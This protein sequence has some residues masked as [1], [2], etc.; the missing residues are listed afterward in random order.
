MPAPKDQTTN[1]QVMSRPMS[2]APPMEE[3]YTALSAPPPTHPPWAAVPTVGE[4]LLH[5][6]VTLTDLAAC[7]VSVRAEFQVVKRAFLALALREHPDRWG[8]PTGSTDP[9]N[10]SRHCRIRATAAF[11]RTCVSFEAI[12]ALVV[13]G[14]VSLSLASHWHDL[15]PEYTA[16]WEH[17]TTRDTPTA[18]P[19]YAYY[20]R[21]SEQTGDNPEWTVQV[22]PSG[23]GHCIRCKKAR[24]T[25]SPPVTEEDGRGSG[26][27]SPVAVVDGLLPD[28]PVDRPYY[29]TKKKQKCHR[30]SPDIIKRHASLEPHAIPY[31][32]VRVGRWEVDRLGM[33]GGWVHL[34]CWQVPHAVWTG[35]TDPNSAS[36]VAHDLQSMD[37]VAWDG[38]SALTPA[39]QRRV[40]EHVR[41]SGNW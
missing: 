33:Y 6:G 10:S 29:P 36:A 41:D 15:A 5:L 7:P 3:G 34:A 21:A 4:C 27:G 40:V 38:F 37:G 26:S 14:R 18:I 30:P 16:W 13:E 39:L 12:R 11:R 9:D 1:L 8:H 28:S 19:S 32:S 31:G 20:C 22:A 25:P 24:R 17:L 23:R 2:S 35:L